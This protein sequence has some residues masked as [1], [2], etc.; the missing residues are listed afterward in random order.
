MPNKHHPKLLAA[1]LDE[2]A[3]R[4]R[5][6]TWVGIPAVLTVVWMHMGH[7]ANIQIFGWM[8]YMFAVMAARIWMGWHW[9]LRSVDAA[10]CRQELAWRLVTSAIYGLGWGGSMLVLN[11]QTLDVLTTF[12]V[13][14]VTA[15][16]GIML[17]S[18]SIIFSVYL[19]FLVPCWLAFMVY[20][21]KASGF[22]SPQDAMIA[23]IAATIF[24]FVLI[25]SSSSI[26]RLNRMFFLRKFELDQALEL[27]QQSNLRE[28][29]LSLQLAEQARRDALTGIYNRRHLAE[30]LDY[31]LSVFSRNH[32][33][34]SVIMIDIDHFKRIN[35][36]HGHDVGDAVLKGVTSVISDA[37]RDIDIFGRWGGEEFLCILPDTEGVDAQHCAER[38]RQRLA[39]TS[40]SKTVTHLS[41]TASFGVATSHASDTA[42][43]LA[44]RCDV[45]LYKAKDEGRNR[46]VA[47]PR[48]EMAENEGLN[49]R[50]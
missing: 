26:A 9:K 23:G 49:Q 48:A 20:I 8:G 6:S 46:V 40:F 18:M 14:T 1:Q 27:T 39:T 28:K 5:H 33:P 12:K 19:A 29:A 44:K 45:A 30:Q 24:A 16:L 7:M 47:E 22:L 41:V 43:T 25:G 4:D 17:N 21:V 10:Q 32:L 13:G 38:L 37:L 31:Q 35:D 36:V 50:A 3:T 42:Q 2:I 34:F 15:A 11:T